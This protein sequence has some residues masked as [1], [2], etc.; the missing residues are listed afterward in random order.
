MAYAYDT[1]FLRFLTT[2]TSSDQV[3][4][5]P[6]QKRFCNLISLNIHQL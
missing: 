6:L 2:K 3:G 1:V 5:Y 4:V